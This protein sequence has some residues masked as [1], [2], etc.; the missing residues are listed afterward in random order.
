MTAQDYLQA[1]R[2]L[3]CVLCQHLGFPP[4]PAEAH[5]VFDTSSR[6]DWLTIPLCA[7]HHRGGTG[8][9]GIGERAWNRMH[10]VS[11]AKLLA[12]T[13]RGLNK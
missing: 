4:S 10:K 13:I 3:G 11:E 6:S 2:D 1:V 5:H 7:E 12:M 8:F 9:H